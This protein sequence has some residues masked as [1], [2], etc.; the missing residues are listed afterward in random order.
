MPVKSTHFATVSQWLFKDKQGL[1]CCQ[2]YSGKELY[3][4]FEIEMDNTNAICQKTFSRLLNTFVDLPPNERFKLH[5]YSIAYRKDV[6]IIL[7]A[8]DKADLKNFI[9]IKQRNRKPPAHLSH[10]L[11]I[12]PSIKHTNI[13]ANKS[14]IKPTNITNIIANTS[15]ITKKNNIDTNNNPI[16]SPHSNNTNIVTNESPIQSKDNNTA[17]DDT[18]IDD[19]SESKNSKKILS[20]S[21]FDLPLSLCFFVGRQRAKLIRARREQ[22][23]ST[24]DIKVVSYK[25]VLQEHMQMPIKKLKTAY[26][27]VDG[28][29][30]MVFEQDEVSLCNPKDI[31]SLRIK[32]LYLMKLYIFSLQY[33]DTIKD[34]SD[35]AG[36]A[37][38]EVNRC[39]DIDLF[40]DEITNCHYVIKSTKTLIR[41]FHMYQDNDAFTNILSINQSKRLPPLLEDNPDVVKS[42]KKICKEHI[43]LLTVEL[44]YNHIH[45]Q[46]IPSLV[47]TIREERK[48][49][50]YNK[51]KLFEE[52][53]FKTLTIKTVY[54][55]MVKLG[56][57][58][59]PRKKS[60]Y[61][62]SHKSP[63][64]IAY[65]KK[66]IT[67]YFE[68]ELRSHRWYQI[69]K[70]EKME[71][72]KKGS[73]DES[74]GYEYD[75]NNQKW[76]EYHVDD[77]LD[78][79]ERCKDLPFGGRL[80]VR[81][82][83]DQEPI[84]ILGQDECI[85]RQFVFSKGMWTCPQ[86]HKQLL[87]KDQGQG[88]MLSSFCSRELG[89]GYT[90]SPESINAVNNI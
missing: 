28:W 26:L 76:Y 53:Q 71:Y 45:E 25:T 55:W 9:N 89:Y 60:Y 79:Q 4:I 47:K 10:T 66:F 65:R 90:P 14:P 80:S 84:M 86:G 18:T 61:V 43:S 62:D 59:E 58:F 12:Y 83:K 82:P 24:A 38:L 85:F 33:F 16:N 40:S 52:F 3:S 37:I 20:F 17:M 54:N 64:N 2:A 32:A 27:A 42:I 22:H 29:K 41:W 68:Y 50:E 44:L 36:L 13:V 63:E 11:S 87:P 57:K 46:I 31:F 88:I 70:E 21:K 69:S 49:Q 8:S 1:R 15:P 56:F 6:F 51:E 19:V 35:I 48:D 30:G 74:S 5:K 75:Q 81:M 23:L 77:H 72:V 73:L 67:R 78:F 7:G 34:F 39:L